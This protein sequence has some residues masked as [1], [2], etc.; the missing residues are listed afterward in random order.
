[1][2]RR[3][4]LWKLDEHTKAKHELLKNY[5]DA[6]IPI[7][8]YYNPRIALID[9]YAGPGIYEGG[10]PGSP[11]IMLRTYLERPDRNKLRAT[12]RFIFVEKDRDRF[13]VLKSE[14]D[15]V[16]RPPKVEAHALNR[17]FDYVVDELLEILGDKRPMPV[18]LFVDSFGYDYD[19]EDIGRL[20]GHPR[21]EA[22]I[23][24]PTP[25]ICR[26]LDDPKVEPT[27]TRA[28]GTDEWKAARAFAHLAD[29]EALICTV[30]E[31]SLRRSTDYVLAFHVQTAPNSS[32]DLFFATNHP[33]GVDA[34]KDAMWKV[35]PTGSYRWRVGNA[36]G[37]TVLFSGA[38]DPEEATAVL[39]QAVGDR[40]FTIEE[41]VEAWVRTR[42]RASHLRQWAIKPLEVAERMAVTRPA[43]SRKRVGT[44]P[45]GTRCRILD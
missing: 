39:W 26:Y 31:A 22:L 40:E 2:P 6:W 14:I 44:Y 35:D 29:R 30:F 24:L 16:A 7:V 42:F 20:V 17:S 45:P 18:F 23:F 21:C 3:S 37:Q 27:I 33:M 32:Y 13:A 5:L 15:K 43:G 36:L 4:T 38:P 10:E 34:M 28:I 25:W 8:G 1:M 11:V 41:A 19:L 12:L 9:G